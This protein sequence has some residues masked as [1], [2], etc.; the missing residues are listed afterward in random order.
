[1]NK[2][3]SIII[4][5]ILIII[6]GI[7]FGY[8]LLPKYNWFLFKPYVLVLHYYAV[9]NP[10]NEQRKKYDEIAQTFINKTL[11]MKDVMVVNHSPVYNEDK[12]GTFIFEDGTTFNYMTKYERDID[13]LKAI[14]KNA[15]AII[16]IIQVSPTIF[17]R[18]PFCQDGFN[19][20]AFDEREEER[21]DGKKFHVLF[22]DITCKH[23]YKIRNMYDSNT[24]DSD[25]KKCI[26]NASGMQK[27]FMAFVRTKGVCVP[28]GANF[29]AILNNNPSKEEVINAMPI[30]KH[31]N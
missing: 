1:M 16:F 9:S 4:I 23:I 13:A 25:M 14:C 21:I 30:K 28:I 31:V 8:K 15:T 12:R 10:D 11:G 24:Y 29:Y 20:L 17:T 18:V 19:I 27:T 2:K 7:L 22:L 6:I 3:T 26:S 5:I